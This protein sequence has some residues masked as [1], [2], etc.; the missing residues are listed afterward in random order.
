MFLPIVGVAGDKTLC[1]HKV[2]GLL[3]A[4]PINL[5]NP[6]NDATSLTT[7]TTHTYDGDTRKL[8]KLVCGP[9]Q[10]MAIDH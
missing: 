6:W 7:Y 2:V 3:H 1:L 4:M 10:S 5:P 9:D 8:Q